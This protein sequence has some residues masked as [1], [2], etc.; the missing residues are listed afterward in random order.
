MK[1]AQLGC[2]VAC[3]DI[4]E[5]INRQTAQAIN[6][7]YGAGTAAAYTCNVGLSDQIADLR[8]RV[9]VDFGSVDLLVHNAGLIAGTSSVTSFD[10]I[11]LHGIVAVNL[12]SHFFVS[13]LR[14][15]L[16]PTSNAVVCW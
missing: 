4:N 15:F 5:A 12:S 14:T 1:F 10:D 2:K 6:R 3:V 9:L 13:S 11:Y 16:G 8:K 7:Q